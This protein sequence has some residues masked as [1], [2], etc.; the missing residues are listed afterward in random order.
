MDGAN[1]L[2]MERRGELK[3]YP[4]RVTPVPLFM[5]DVAGDLAGCRVARIAADGYKDSEIKDYLD[6]ARLRW[7]REFRRVGAGRQGGAD[8][9][10]FQRLVLSK[11]LKMRRSLAL[12]TA[13]ANST[14]RRDG[15]GN[16]GLDKSRS[17]GRIDLLS[18][19]VIAGG[20]A[21]P[22]FDRAPRRGW[23]SAGLA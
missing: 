3:T 20:L 5:E 6:R 4:G 18:A 17:R 16:P 2:E 1:Y 22:H 12:S 13:I 23:R 11:R 15:N 19:A 10:A 7:P 8:V 9:R 21:E 14:I